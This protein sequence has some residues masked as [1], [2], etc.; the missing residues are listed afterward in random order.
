MYLG[1][2]RV[3][4]DGVEYPA[5]I[6]EDGIAVLPSGEEKKLTDEQFAIV[7]EKLEEAKK[8]MAETAP[9]TMPPEEKA[10]PAKEKA[11]E[12]T[13]V[14]AAEPEVV[15]AGNK[16]EEQAEAHQ[17]KISASQ[18]QGKMEAEN[19][20]RAQK[21]K[22]GKSFAVAIILAIL[23]IAET[24]AVGVGYALGYVSVS[25]PGSTVA[26]SGYIETSDGAVSSITPNN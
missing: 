11:A 22:K 18:L 9:L 25:I 10:E 15:Q 21:P 1:K 6:T 14:E 4:I 8:A 5:K 17:E 26:A 20:Y 16:P 23:L 13:P 24:A 3:K 2:I 19:N 12:A 7:K